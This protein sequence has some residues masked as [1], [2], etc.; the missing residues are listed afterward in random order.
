MWLFRMIFF[1]DPETTGE[2]YKSQLKDSTPLF[3]LSYSLLSQATSDFN[4]AVL[5]Y[6]QL[7]DWRMPAVSIIQN[8]GKSF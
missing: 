4:V 3:Q 1:D 6:N 8:T 5:M 7:F 2:S